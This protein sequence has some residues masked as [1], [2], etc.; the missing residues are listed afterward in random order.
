MGRDFVQIV[1][2][3]MAVPRQRT[4]ANLASG[5]GRSNRVNAE[6]EGGEQELSLRLLLREEPVVR[7]NICLKGTD[8]FYYCE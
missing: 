6:K 4:V 3:G 2:L 8:G 5:T 1:V 7:L